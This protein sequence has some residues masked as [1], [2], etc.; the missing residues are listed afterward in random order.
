[1]TVIRAI[2][3]HDVVQALHPRTPTERDLVGMAVG[4][5]IDTALS[6]Y[7]HEFAE[8]RRPTASRM[9][10]LAA[11]VLD[12][13]LSDADVPLNPEERARALAPVPEVLKLFR[14]SELFGRPRPRSRL[15]VINGDGGVYAQPDFWDGRRRIYEMKSYRAVPPPPD[16]AVQ[17]ELF[18]LAFPGF[19]ELLACFDRHA[20][21]VELL[22]YSVP[23]LVEPR[24]TEV[25]QTAYRLAREHGAEKVLEYVDS[26]VIR[27][28]CPT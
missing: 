2:A 5:A 8:G 14:E 19:S 17:L 21:P 20:R 24:R 26:P 27:Y 12:E 22:L 7:S 9:L 23:E 16:V 4:K 15:I 28:S 10:T 13:E 11:S 3:T 25:M 6:R 1:M 18:Q